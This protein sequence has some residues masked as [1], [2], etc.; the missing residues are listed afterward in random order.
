[1]VVVLGPYREGTGVAMVL[2]GC[3][4]VMEGHSEDRAEEASLALVKVVEEPV[5]VLAA[6]RVLRAC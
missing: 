2:E 3:V 4:V 6:V 5:V 1:M